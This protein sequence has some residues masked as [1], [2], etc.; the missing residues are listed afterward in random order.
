MKSGRYVSSTRELKRIARN[1][2]Y[3]VI[4]GF[5]EGS[6]VYDDDKVITVIPNHRE[7]GGRGTA[8]RILEAL[9]TGESSF[10]RR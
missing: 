3:K 1:S 10:R 5:R 9:A 2:G 8:I 7:V 4:D 6:R